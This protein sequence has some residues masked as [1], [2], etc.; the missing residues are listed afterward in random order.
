MRLLPVQLH[1]ATYIETMAGFSLA[2]SMALSKVRERFGERLINY[3]SKNRPL[4][5]TAL[6][7]RY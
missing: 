7:R 4:G 6:Q 2:N 5:L 1:G 3:Q